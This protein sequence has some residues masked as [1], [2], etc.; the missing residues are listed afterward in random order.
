MH[1][2]VTLSSAQTVPDVP[3]GLK[4]HVPSFPLAELFVASGNMPINQ[5]I[6]YLNQA[7]L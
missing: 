2:L 4:D 6:L 7:E 3:G 1:A 5:E